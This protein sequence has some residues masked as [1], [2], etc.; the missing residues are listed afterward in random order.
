MYDYKSIQKRPEPPT[1]NEVL[2]K[3]YATTRQIEDVKIR[4][5]KISHLREF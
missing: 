5:F 3:V 1:E 2:I 4:G